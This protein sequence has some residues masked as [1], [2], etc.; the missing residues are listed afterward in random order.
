MGRN[1]AESLADEI[2]ALL[3]ENEAA[4]ALNQ[5]IL[6]IEKGGG[7]S[8]SIFTKCDLVLDFSASQA[9]LHYLGNLDIKT[10]CMSF[11]MLQNGKYLV[12]LCEGKG[13]T[14][15]LKD[16]EIQ[17]NVESICNDKLKNLFASTNDKG[18]RY[19]GSCSDISTELPDDVV[20]IH[21]GIAAHFIKKTIS[22]RNPSI[23]L[24][25]FGNDMTCGRIEFDVAGIYNNT[26]NGWNIRISQRAIQGMKQFRKVRLPN[27]TG[28]V[29]VGGFDIPARTVY[30]GAALGAPSDSMEWPTSY[31]RG[32]KGL[33]AV[34]AK[35]KK[36]TGE[37]L[38]Y[39]GEWHSHPRG[40]GDGPSR[41]DKTAHRIFSEKMSD[42]GLPAVMLIQG[43]KSVPNIL[44]Q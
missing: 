41:D 2:N 19:G 3:N 29:L 12:S 27:E 35:I 18:I 6:E 36:S 30:V 37:C 39:V 16:L 34:L 10:R 15:R 13:R 28:G 33:R 5:S 4:M 38:S 9:V 32:V 44:V 24:W 8:K 20:S 14:V 31:I 17:L 7:E 40:C 11:F 1:K 26:I 21:S 22:F 42:E 25:T 23:N 43:D